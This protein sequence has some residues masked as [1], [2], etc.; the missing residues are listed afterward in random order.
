[1]GDTTGAW[2]AL[3]AHW[4][5]KG[6]SGAHYAPA[7]RKLGR[8]Q[9]AYWAEVAGD[10]YLIIIILLHGADYYNHMAMQ[11]LYSLAYTK[12]ATRR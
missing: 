11:V 3:R 12:G 7:R 9:Q 5:L 2:G 4:A 6:R 10:F 1:M 8:T